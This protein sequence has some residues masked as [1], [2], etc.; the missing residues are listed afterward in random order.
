MDNRV[1]TISEAGGPLWKLIPARM[2]E[3]LVGLGEVDLVG[4]NDP[5]EPIEVN[6][7]GFPGE[8]FT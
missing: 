3:K 5:G 6:R 2:C 4:I 7:T 1:K 8:C